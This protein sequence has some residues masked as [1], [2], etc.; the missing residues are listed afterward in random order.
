[1]F[2]HHN[3]GHQ[4]KEN[5]QGVGINA[6]MSEPQAA[7]G[8][9]V[10]PHMTHIL[11]ERK[12]VVETYTKTL[13]LL[14]VQLLQIRP[15]TQWNFCYFPVIFK[16]ESQLLK[17]KKALENQNIFPRRYFYPSLN[18]LDY[19]N[20]QSCP[21]SEQIASRILCLPLYPGLKQLEVE[22]ILEI[23]QNEL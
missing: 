2:L 8:L 1:M 20:N 3:F 18:T 5:F 14:D 16:S 13:K 12:K 6:K 17:A 4:G 23:I 10:F 9:A 15:E 22:Q 7:M 19:T 21:V 11:Y